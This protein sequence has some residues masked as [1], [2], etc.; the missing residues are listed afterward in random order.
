MSEWLKILLAEIDRKN[1]E[2]SAAED[3]RE[4]RFKQEK[5]STCNK[6]PLESK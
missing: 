2:S 3:E 4:R 5:E 6:E 1:A